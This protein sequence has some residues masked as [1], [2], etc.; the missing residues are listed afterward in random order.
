[1][2]LF[3]ERPK[4]GLYRVMKDK[5]FLSFVS[6]TRWSGE[7]QGSEDIRSFLPGEFYLLLEITR[8]KHEE[9][10]VARVLDETGKIF[11]IRFGDRWLERVELCSS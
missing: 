4:P 10:W 2:K 9:K 3:T 6:S 11:W 8:S 7:P 5:R 1:M